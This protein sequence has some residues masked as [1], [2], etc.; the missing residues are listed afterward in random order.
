MLVSVWAVS[1]VLSAQ[2]VFILFLANMRSFHSRRSVSELCNT[3]L[4]HRNLVKHPPYAHL[5]PA[6]GCDPRNADEDGWRISRGSTLPVP[7]SK[8]ARQTSFRIALE[9]VLL[10]CLSRHFIVVDPSLRSLVHRFRDAS[11]ER[12]DDAVT[13]KGRDRTSA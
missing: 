4:R 11:G 5:S 9:S 3:I 2:Y 12:S 1:A 8:R 13:D 7:S 10:R 6:F